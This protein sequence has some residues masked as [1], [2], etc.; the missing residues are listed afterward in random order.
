MGNRACVVWQK[1]YLLVTCVST[2]GKRL[3]NGKVEKRKLK[4]TIS[5]GKYTSL[6]DFV[7]LPTVDTEFNNY[8]IVDTPGILGYC[9]T[10]L[11]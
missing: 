2:S 10:F 11:C 9:C 6:H 3:K 4:Y 7:L 8:N 1:R 5:L